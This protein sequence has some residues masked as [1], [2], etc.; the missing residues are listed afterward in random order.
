VWAVAWIR[1]R[2]A[3]TIIGWHIVSSMT[4]A[5]VFFGDIRLRLPYD[6]YAILLA[7]EVWAVVIV[8]GWGRLRKGR[9][10]Q[11]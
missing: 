1:R 9:G 2:P 5:A 10:T 6:P 4:V 8:F 7:W 11:S 3:M